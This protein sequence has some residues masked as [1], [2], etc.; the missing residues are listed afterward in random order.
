MFYDFFALIVDFFATPLF[1]L[2]Y[3]PFEPLIS[4][5]YVKE[6]AGW[7]GRGRWVGASLVTPRV[8]SL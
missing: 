7:C 8:Y 5:E 6:A 4:V 1:Y 3:A 2:A